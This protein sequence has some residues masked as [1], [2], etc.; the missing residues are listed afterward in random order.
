MIWIDNIFNL[1]EENINLESLSPFFLNDNTIKYDQ[2]NSQKKKIIDHNYNDNDKDTF[3]ISKYKYETSTSTPTPTNNTIKKDENT[4]NMNIYPIHKMHDQLFWSITFALHEEKEFAERYNTKNFEINE[5]E[6]ISQYIHKTKCINLKTKITKTDISKMACEIISEK[7]IEWDHVFA[8]ASYYNTD[9][10]IFDS[11]TNK[12]VQYQCDKPLNKKILNK[13]TKNKKIYFE[14]K[15]TVNDL[16]KLTIVNFKLEKFNKPLKGISYYKS[17]DLDDICV[18]L[19]IKLE[20]KTTKPKIYE[21]ISLHC[22]WKNL[23]KN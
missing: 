5:K 10:Y 4:N 3:V 20:K 17:K 1:R 15:Y 18:I 6:K 11:Y 7:K 8:L 22:V 2:E 19:D 14:K 16:D 21:I 23:L 13:Y 12:Y 9:I